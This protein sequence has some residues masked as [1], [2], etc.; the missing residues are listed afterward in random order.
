MGGEYLPNLGGA[1]YEPFAAGN[2]PAGVDGPA[3][4]RG[5]MIKVLPCCRHYRH[6]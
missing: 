6:S 5:G 2:N 4:R 3:Y 1:G